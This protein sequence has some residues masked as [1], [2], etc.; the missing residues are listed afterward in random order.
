MLEGSLST[1]PTLG[2]LLSVIFFISLKYK[3]VLLYIVFLIYVDIILTNTHYPFFA[4]IFI[5]NHPP[6]FMILGYTIK[7]GFTWQ[8]DFMLRNILR[9]FQTYVVQP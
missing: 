7:S 6:A 5:Q 3:H 9:Q 4:F 2:V 1:P 8:L